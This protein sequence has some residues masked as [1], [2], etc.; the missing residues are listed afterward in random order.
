MI[1]EERW[2]LRNHNRLT[3]GWVD[4]CEG[5]IEGP[6]THA[7]GCRCRGRGDGNACG[8]DCF[9]RLHTLTYVDTSAH[10]SCLSFS[11]LFPFFLLLTLCSLPYLPSF[12]P[13]YFCCLSLSLAL[14]LVM[15][16]FVNCCLLGKNKRKHI[17]YH[18]L[19]HP[20]LW[21]CFL[22]QS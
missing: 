5:K 22:C 6:Q 21:A 13:I 2:P 17:F 18:D 15:P 4:H 20:S 3:H 9:V 10:L 7:A 1:T 11:T 16:Q 14:C 8:G 19:V 12:C